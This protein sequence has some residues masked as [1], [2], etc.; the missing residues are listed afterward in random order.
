MDRKGTIG[1][2]DV[3]K[4]QDPNNWFEMW[5]IKTGRKQSPDLSNVL[6][7]AMGATTEALNHAWFRKHM[8]GGNEEAITR[9]FYEERT[10]YWQPKKG[11]A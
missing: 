10:Q 6:P 2:S 5:E 9:M 8:T 1:G 4:L 3:A 7:V 11:A